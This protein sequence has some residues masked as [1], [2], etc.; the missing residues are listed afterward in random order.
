MCAL[1]YTGHVGPMA[2]SGGSVV[3]SCLDDDGSCA[4][5]VRPALSVAT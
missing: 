4:G 5:E 1:V 2:A 3:V